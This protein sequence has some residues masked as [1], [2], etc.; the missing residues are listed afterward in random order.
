MAEKHQQTERTIRE[1]E[2]RERER[3]ESEQPDLRDR[4]AWPGT[5]GTAPWRSWVAAN[6]ARAENERKAKGQ[7]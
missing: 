1:V 5:V 6:S 3:L 7:R 2:Q 4:T